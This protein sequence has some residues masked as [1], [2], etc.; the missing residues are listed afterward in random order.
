MKF[1]KTF[2]KQLDEETLPEEW[3]NKAIQ[4]KS[5]KKIINKTALE[6]EKVGVSRDDMAV[7]YE[8]SKTHRKVRPVLRLNVPA[9]DE[10]LIVDQLDQL[11]YK[12]EITE[13]DPEQSPQKQ[14]QQQPRP[15]T[16]EEGAVPDSPQI[17]VSPEFEFLHPDVASGNSC[18][19]PSNSSLLEPPLDRT[20]SNQS[21]Q[22]SIEDSIHASL[23]EL[24]K[25]AK[26]SVVTNTD[27]SPHYLIT[28]SL[29]EDAKFF[30][31]L[32]DEIEALN[33]FRSERESEI[34]DWVEKIA[35]IVAKASSPQVRRNDLY[36]WRQIFQLYSESQIFFSTLERS[37]GTLNNNTSKMRY[38]Q[39][40]QEVE[41]QGLVKRFKQKESLEAF[42][43]FKQLNDAILKV[44]NFQSLNILAI[45]KILKKFDKRTH[46]DSKELF[47]ELVKSAQN[48]NIMQE[49]LGRDVFAII[50]HRL[51]NIIPQVD[52]Y[53]CPICCELAYKPVRLDCGHL[54]CLR[55][56][57]KLRRKGEDKC[58]LCRK[59]VVMKADSG[60]LDV[61]LMEYMKVYFPKE[62]KEKEIQNDKEIIQEQYGKVVDTDKQPCVIV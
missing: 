53:L 33:D 34:V 29:H 37:A 54:F 44:S 5:L 51:L 14:A 3:V 49:S 20:V 48:A 52:D 15:E 35:G 40:L 24:P 16:I 32:Y 27:K 6:L 50:G 1:A 45:S 4:Y 59:N 58:P 28:V 31:T 22:D 42:M 36:V 12:Y 19:T 47:P 62:V 11:G 17:P 60:N 7:N 23:R 38:A 21:L 10:K 46:L 25:S 2:Q 55:C 9:L 30:Q 57:I 8:I 39:F 18:F 41:D 61:S 13:I 56:L 26:S 43:E